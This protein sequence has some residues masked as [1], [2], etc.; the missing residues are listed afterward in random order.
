MTTAIAS[1]VCVGW[2]LRLHLLHE[3]VDLFVDARAGAPATSAAGL[4]SGEGGRGR[5]RSGEV[6]SHVP[7]YLRV[8][9]DDGDE[10]RHLLRVV[11]EPRQ[12]PQ[13]APRLLLGR[14]RRRRQQ[15]ERRHAQLHAHLVEH[16]RTDA[17]T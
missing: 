15:L 7:V 2:Y 3:E 9:S 17:H 5:V 10:L 6:G 13:R 16:L 4:R 11:R 14:R 12:R 1:L 8:G